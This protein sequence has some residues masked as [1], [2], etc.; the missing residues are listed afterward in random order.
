MLFPTPKIVDLGS[1]LAPFGE[2]FGILAQFCLGPFLRTWKLQSMHDLLCFRH[3]RGLKKDYFFDDFGN[4]FGR[5]SEVVIG[6]DL[7]TVF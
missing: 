7:D 3:I 4:M 6:M 1:I 5:I 2:V